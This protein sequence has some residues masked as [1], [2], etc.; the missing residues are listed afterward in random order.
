LRADAFFSFGALLR[1][2]VLLGLLPFG[3]LGFDDA[4]DFFR[5]GREVFVNVA[6]SIAPHGSGILRPELHL[7]EPVILPPHTWFRDDRN[8]CQ[9]LTLTTLEQLRHFLLEDEL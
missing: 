2:A 8:N 4:D 5:N 7:S 6:A 1:Q 9:P 3:L